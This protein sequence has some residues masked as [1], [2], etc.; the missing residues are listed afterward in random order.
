M[1]K[2]SQI[3]IGT[4]LIV[5]VIFF[6]YSAECQFNGGVKLFGDGIFHVQRIL[7]IRNAFLHLQIPNWVNFST[8]FGIGQAVNGMYPDLT[9]W[10]LVL[11]TNFLSRNIKL[12]QLIF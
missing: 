11:I 4:L 1:K 12:Q 2:V 5:L 3:R 10:P 9:L 6:I 8:F 7:E